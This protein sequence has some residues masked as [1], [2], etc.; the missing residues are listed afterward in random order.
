MKPVPISQAR[1]DLFRL[2]DMAT[3]QEGFKVPI[4]RRGRQRGAVLV[5]AAYLER[6]ENSAGAL[7]SPEGLGWSRLRGT[8]K[9]IGDPETF[10]KQT[11]AEQNALTEAK[12]QRL[13]RDLT[14]EPSRRK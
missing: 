12:M 4:T 1:R 6:L 13:Y 9:I 10:L 11:R 14:P 8:M 2:F 7:P 5:S 3:R